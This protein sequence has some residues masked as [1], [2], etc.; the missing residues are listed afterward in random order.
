MNYAEQIRNVCK[1]IPSSGGRQVRCVAACNI[2][3]SSRVYSG[4][5]GSEEPGVLRYYE[6]GEKEK[7]RV[8]RRAEVAPCT[9]TACIL[10][11][12]FEGR[13]T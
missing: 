9:E 1:A 11:I 6:K 4:I 7:R 10:M 13:K 12:P 2:P 3:T 5:S 8:L